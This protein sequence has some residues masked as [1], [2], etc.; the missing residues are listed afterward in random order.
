MVAS[1]SPIAAQLNGLYLILDANAFAA[2]DPVD[3]VTAAAAA[4][5]RLFQY[6]DKG[7]SM[8]EAYRQA[9]RLRQVCADVGAIFIVNDR[10]DLAMAVDAD[11][12]HLGQGDLPLKH[13]RSLMGVD[14]LIGVSTHRLDEVEEATRSGA[15]Y[16]GFGPIFE[17]GTKA[18]HEPVVGLEGLR[19]ARARTRLPIFAIGGVS[20]ETVPEIKHAGADGV[21]V[22]SGV[23]KAPDIEKAVRAFLT[24]LG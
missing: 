13:A 22:I 11:G 18:D 10:C 14:R 17:T 19:Q 9:V 2:R 16:I 23:A 15:D 12:V 5:A 1:S 8:K 6:R 24:E 4:G 3:V 21:A 20:L 7:A